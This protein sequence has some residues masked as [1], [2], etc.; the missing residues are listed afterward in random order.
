MKHRVEAQVG[1]V[2]HVLA[3]A[4]VLTLVVLATL[5]APAMAAPAEPTISLS[6]L[7][8]KLASGPMAGYFL[9][10]VGG[11]TQDPQQIPATVLSVV[12]NQT[13][14]GALI[15]FEASGPVIDKA[16]GVASG[17][18]GSPLYVDDG[19]VFKLA[20]AVSYGP[21]YSALALATPIEYMSAI[22]T[23][24]PVKA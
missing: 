2:W 17:M 10:V 15:L 11:T 5:A 9:T 1:P 16:G 19:G 7:E 24:F 23:D 13:V 18:S 20:G 3:L 14:D 12:P 6:D 22:Q 21:A 8:A 4:L